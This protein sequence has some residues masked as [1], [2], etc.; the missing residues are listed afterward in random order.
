MVTNRR[1]LRSAVGAI[2][3]LLLG[4][5][6]G[7]QLGS[8]GNETDPVPENALNGDPGPSYEE[9]GVPLGYAHTTAGAIS[10]ATSYATVMSRVGLGE[11]AYPKALETLA[12]P[13]WKSE[14]RQLAENT[15]EFVSSEYGVGSTASFLP[16]RFRVESYDNSASVVAV[17]GVL[18]IEDP[19][20][21]DLSQS[22]L[23]TTIRLVWLDDWRVDGAESLP[24]PAPVLNAG[25][26]GTE[27]NLEGFEDYGRGPLP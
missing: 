1:A 11:V 12:A 16:M 23:K 10:A 19:T 15:L 2:L 18:V 4:V 26:Q 5:T 17:W 22:W 21:V 7:W 27:E 20:M 13:E 25:D 8:R 3:V 9:D 14:A 6:I 24:G